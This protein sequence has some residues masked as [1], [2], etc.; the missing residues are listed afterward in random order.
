MSGSCTSIQYT[1]LK[2]YY[3]RQKGREALRLLDYYYF[4]ISRD[5]SM[6]EGFYS[7]QTKQG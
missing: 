4:L 2:N 7:S 3:H 5:L 6:H 1:E